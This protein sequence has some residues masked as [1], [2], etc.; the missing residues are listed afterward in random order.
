MTDIGAQ[1]PKRRI[2]VS[3]TSSTEAADAAPARRLLDEYVNLPEGGCT[4]HATSTRL[5]SLSNLAVVVGAADL[6]SNG[7]DHMKVSPEQ[8]S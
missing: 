5:T 6:V 4:L 3:G 7:K 1:P 8:R 2:L